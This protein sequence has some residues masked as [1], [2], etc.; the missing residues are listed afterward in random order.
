MLFVFF[1]FVLSFCIFF[2]FF[3]LC[4][5]VFC[6]IMKLARR[7]HTQTHTHT[8]TRMELQQNGDG[9]IELEVVRKDGRPIV[10]RP[11]DVNELL[12][13]QGHTIDL[14]D[15]VHVRLEEYSSDTFSSSEE[16]TEETDSETSASDSRSSDRT[17][18]PPGRRRLSGYGAAFGMH[19]GEE[20]STTQ[21]LSFQDPGSNKGMAAQ[22]GRISDSNVSGKV[23][24][25]RRDIW[26]SFAPPMDPE[27]NHNWLQSTSIMPGANSRR[28]RLPPIMLHATASYLSPSDQGQRILVYGGITSFGKKVEK[29]L[30][31]FSVLTG[32]W[33]RVEGKHFFFPG[34]YGHAA[35]VVER[36]QRLVVI[37][38]MSPGG[39]PVRGERNSDEFSKLRSRILFPCED[40]TKT[41]RPPSVRMELKESE[42]PTLWSLA[43]R[44][45]EE[46]PIGFMPVLFEMNLK[47]LRWRVVQTSPEIP[48]ALHT[49]VA[50]SNTIYLFGGVTNRL[51]VSAQLIGIH[52]ENYNISLIRSS[53]VSPK[54]RY[55][56]SAAIYGN[57]MI[58]YGGFDAYNEPLADVWAFDLVNERWEQLECHGTPARGAHASCIV[59][60]SLFVI[61]GFEGA[62]TSETK[63]TSSIY[64]LQL[65]P[66]STGQYLWKKITVRPAIPPLAFSAACHCADDVSFIV[67]GGCTVTGIKAKRRPPDSKRVGQLASTNSR[68]ARNISRHDSDGNDYN[69][70]FWQGLLPVD[71]GFAFTFPLKKKRDATGSHGDG[72]GASMHVNELGAVTDPEELTPEFK[73]FVRRQ[74]EF[75]LKKNASRSQAMKR[76]ILDELE[77]MEPNLY[78]TS[79]EIELLLEKSNLLCESCTGYNMET[80]PHNIP[81]REQRLH[82]T[83]KCI[84]LSRQIRDV[85]MSMKGYAP[86]VT[87]VKSRTH[88]LQSGEKFEDHSVAKPFRRVIVMGLLREMKT[89]LR[90]I[91]NLNMILKTVE[92]PEKKEYL[93]AVDTMQERKTEFVQVVKDILEKYIERRVESLISAADRQKDN[94]RRLAEIVEKIRHEKIFQTEGPDPQRERVRQMCSRGEGQET[95]QKDTKRS[96]SRSHHYQHRH[97]RSRSTGAGYY[98]DEA[99][100]VISLQPKELQQLLRKIHLVHKVA[101]SFSSYCQST[102]SD[103][104]K[105][106]REMP[107]PSSSTAPPALSNP[108]TP[109]LAVPA[110]L[111]IVETVPPSNVSPATHTADADLGAA[112][113]SEIVIRQS[114]AIREEAI[115]TATSV[116]QSVCA[117]AKELETSFE[118]DDK[119]NSQT[120]VNKDEKRPTLLFLSSLRPLLSCKT[121]LAQLREKIS[122]IRVNR[123]AVDDVAGA[124]QDV[125]A[126]KRCEKLSKCLS[127][128]VQRLTAS[129]LSKAGARPPRLTFR[130]AHSLGALKPSSSSLALAPRSSPALFSSSSSPATN[131]HRRVLQAMPTVSSSD[132]AAL[133]NGDDSASQTQ[134]ETTEQE[135]EKQSTCVFGPLSTPLMLLDTPPLPKAAAMPEIPRTICLTSNEAQS[136]VAPFCTTSSICN[137][138]AI[139]PSVRD[140]KVI[141]NTQQEA[142]TWT[143]KDSSIMIPHKEFFTAVSSKDASQ[144]PPPRIFVSKGPQT[145]TA[146]A[147]MAIPAELPSF[148]ESLSAIHIRSNT[149]GDKNTSSCMVSLS[150]GCFHGSSAPGVAVGPTN[151][152]DPQQEA[153]CLEEDY[154]LFGR[155][156]AAEPVASPCVVEDAQ[157]RQVLAAADSP[158]V[159]RS[160]HAVKVSPPVGTPAGPTVTAPRKQVVNPFFRK[161][162]ASGSHPGASEEVS[163]KPLKRGLFSGKLTPGEMHIIQARERL[164]SSS[165]RR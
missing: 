24:R 116:G 36:L 9:K 106:S 113:P 124:P 142:S 12:S 58:V 89:E 6:T 152:V 42:K 164:R 65:V 163:A 128:L 5:C 18:V 135:P 52:A 84:S 43:M 71:D 25:S 153:L 21:K 136:L 154:F 125:E 73:A 108:E 123:W 62:I 88:R 127:A 103:V 61:G 150:P 99:K 27:R 102:K 2:C 104:Q 94:M 57:W 148:G 68:D 49:A 86:G 143:N 138:G 147:A 85:L 97:R 44:V 101:T 20:K 161:H 38:G 33:R 81:D 151:C 156:Y 149:D 129:F 160:M 46:P 111:A 93:D 117:F 60:S 107:P 53:A 35:V 45:E 146:A 119:P 72:S 78:L 28:F 83:E 29:E 34:N 131:K 112:S 69:E 4:V 144:S 11:I 79:E 76:T 133:E 50:T 114:D 47:T 48:A 87:A 90:R 54:A 132:V 17:D 10:R 141:S 77:N 126:Q 134:E 139:I 7:T 30:Y 109:S 122:G 1:C 32:N 140:T 8:H 115:E 16:G 14:G 39:Q 23:L 118:A 165:S 55:L 162:V 64:E 37:G 3:L 145:T 74:E 75:I 91:H 158:L 110:A 59:G 96:V 98:K 26:A 15:G 137:E 31:E 130:R 66:T 63:P 105:S 100:A 157:K 82:H 19:G 22:H 95:P 80:M 51:L 56:H 40:K 120:D 92:W 155:R 70:N 121:Q 13:K 159:V 41:K 67:Y